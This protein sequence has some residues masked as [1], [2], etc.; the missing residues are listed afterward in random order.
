M[1]RIVQMIEAERKR[2]GWSQEE[3]ATRIGVSVTTYNRWV[4]GKHDPSP[5]AEQRL[6]DLLNRLK[7]EGKRRR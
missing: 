4:L 3:M 6:R 2:R 5:L 1:K 7:R